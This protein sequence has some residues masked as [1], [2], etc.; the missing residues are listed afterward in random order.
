MVTVMES[1]LTCTAAVLLT[2][3]IGGVDGGAQVAVVV[4]SDA[5]TTSNWERNANTASP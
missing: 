2:S 5:E 1:R 3:I 4:A